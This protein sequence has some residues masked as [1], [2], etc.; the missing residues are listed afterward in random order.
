[1]GRRG[2]SG[3][4]SPRAIRSARR[5][6]APKRSATAASGSVASWPSVPM[7]SRSSFSGRSAEPVRAASV[8][9]PPARSP[10]SRSRSRST[11]RPARKERVIA[12]KTIVGARRRRALRA[13]GVGAEP[14]LARPEPHALS[15]RLSRPLQRPLQASPKAHQAGRLEERLARTPRLD[16]GADPLQL[17]QR[18]LP[19]RLGALGVGRHQ[20]QRSGGA[21]APRRGASPRGCRTPRP[22]PRPLRSPGGRPA[23]A[24]VPAA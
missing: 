21:R 17:P 1:M 4:S 14:G 6:I 24:P 9:P 20:G 2:R 8:V 10:G 23:P 16:L 5:P 19:G 12:P 11:D 15:D 22:A 7:P 13:A 18:P 3:S